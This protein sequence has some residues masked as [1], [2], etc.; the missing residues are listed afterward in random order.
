MIRCWIAFV[1]MLGLQC[2]LTPENNVITRYIALFRN[3]DSAHQYL[4]ALKWACVYLDV[5]TPWASDPSVLQTL[6]GVKKITR[7]ARRAKPIL[8]WNQIELLVRRAFQVGEAEVGTIMAL[9][10]VFM[11]RVPSEC[12]PLCQNSEHSKIQAI[13]EGDRPAL[14]VT[15]ASRKNL[16]QGSQLI[17][18]CVCIRERKVLCPVHS[19]HDHLQRF[20][21]FGPGRIFTTSAAAF[22]KVMRRL[23]ATGG[24]PFAGIRPEDCG[25][26][27]LRRSSANELMR[28]GS[29]LGQ[30][31]HAA[32]W[33][34]GGFLSYLLKA[35]VNKEAI[36][37]C[38][39][40]ESDSDDERS[41]RRDTRRSVARPGSAHPRPARSG[42]PFF[43]VPAL[44]DSGEAI[45][46]TPEVDYEALFRVAVARPPTPPPQAPAKR[47]AASSSSESSPSKQAQ[48]S[49]L[50]FVRH[51]DP[52]SMDE[53]S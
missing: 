52:F 28:R 17:R 25:S 4:K 43:E 38:M 33:G 2:F 39:V 41:E 44:G 22:Q 9:S 50:D 10:T 14:L 11:F 40:A 15:L 49:M 8:T 42:D 35:D 12:L 21:R 3:G 27:I 18:R 36:F 30:I 47:P 46:P 48:K 5:P 23:I 24:E 53:F 16:P 37:D 1:D 13:M 51:R 7:S 34:G 26:H 19:L 20:K 32:Q 6:R 29:S 45:S 31:M